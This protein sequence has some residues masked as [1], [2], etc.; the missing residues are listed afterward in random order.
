VVFLS[1]LV[2]HSWDVCAQSEGSFLSFTSEPGDYIG[3]G[4]SRIFTP[5]DSDFTAMASADGREMAV[6][7]FPQNAENG[8]FWFLHLAAPSGQQ[9]VPGVYE[10]A[11]RWPFQ[12]PGEPGLDFSGDGRGCNTLTGRFE[13]HDA[14]FGPLGYLERFRAT[15]EQHCEGAPA[16]LFGEVVIVNPPAPPALTVTLA[17]DRDGIVKRVTGTAIVH[18]TVTCSE[19]TSVSLHGTL[20]QRVRRIFVAQGAFDLSF[21]CSP[22][23]TTWQA[24]VTAQDHFAYGRGLAQL[25]VRASAI[26]PNFGV[27]VTTEARGLVRLRFPQRR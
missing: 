17:I 20:T 6:S 4:Q 15:F 21:E 24:E 7:I 25:D 8:V 2:L 14:L 5:T 10:G 26:D 19:A 12:P 16:S 11:T 22:T 18:G 13:V 3:Q 1:L 27:P 23:P 9:L